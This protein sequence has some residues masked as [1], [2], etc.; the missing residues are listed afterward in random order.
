MSRSTVLSLLL[1]S[2]FPLVSLPVSHAFSEISASEPLAGVTGEPGRRENPVAE[3]GE[4][5][6]RLALGGKIEWGEKWSRA[7]VGDDD[8]LQR[9][10]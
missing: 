3:G 7:L 5:G 2:L 1:L 6:Q 4:V 10:M 9:V 8:F